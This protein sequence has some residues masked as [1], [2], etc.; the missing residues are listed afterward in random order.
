MFKVGDIVQIKNSPTSTRKITRICDAY[1]V[2]VIP[3]PGSKD[4]VYGPM[5]AM[6]ISQYELVPEPQY[7]FEYQWV[8]KDENEVYSVT[9]VSYTEKAFQKM[10]SKYRILNLFISFFDYPINIYMVSKRLT[11]RKCFR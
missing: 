11:A 9:V 3:L 7:D 1:H 10:F 8:I 4:E 6:M 5:E 2:D